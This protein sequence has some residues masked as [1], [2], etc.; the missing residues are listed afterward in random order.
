LLLSAGLLRWV[1]AQPL[2]RRRLSTGAATP[3]LFTTSLHV[4]MLGALLSV[5][6]RSIYPVYEVGALLWGMPAIED[7]RLAAIVMRTP[8]ALVF[9]VAVAVTFLR[10]LAAMERR[11]GRDAS[12]VGP[13]SP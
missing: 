10:W 9:L 11:A 6:P 5:A 12:L 3:Y 1:R 13:E 8:M 7:Q 2:G 4:T